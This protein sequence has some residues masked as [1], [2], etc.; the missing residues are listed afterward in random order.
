MNVRLGPLDT[1]F[2]VRVGESVMAAGQRAGL[3]W[4]TICGGNGQCGWCHVEIV[5]T[6]IPLSPPDAAEVLTL[7]HVVKA[8]A[9]MTIR[10]A[11]Q[12]RP[13]GDL[14]IER[15]GISKA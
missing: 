6:D 8:P 5:S 1:S 13:E 9:G 4:P 7:K 14:V 11:C 2:P 15:A 3:K 10:L 12:I